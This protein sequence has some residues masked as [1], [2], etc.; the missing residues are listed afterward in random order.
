MLDGDGRLTFVNPH[1]QRRHFHHGGQ[2]ALTRWTNLYFPV[3]Q[4]LWGDAIGGATGTVFRDPASGSNIADIPVYTT[5]SKSDNFFAHVF[6][7]S[8]A[9]GDDA[10]HI[11]ALR[12]AI[13]LADSGTPNDL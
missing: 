11:E 13:D 1:D 12:K 6:Y 2:F 7:W 5:P 9:F 10:P 8:T 4:L 3:S